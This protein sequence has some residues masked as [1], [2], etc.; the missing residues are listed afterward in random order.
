MTTEE[1]NTKDKEQEAICQKWIQEQLELAGRVHIPD[2]GDWTDGRV[3][4][5][6]DDFSL[7]SL[8]ESINDAFTTTSSSSS[9]P[10]YYGGVDVS[11]PKHETD[12]SVAVYVILDA[13]TLQVV[14]K[15]HKYFHLEI[16]YIPTFLAFR[17]IGPLERLIATQRRVRPSLTP[18]AIWVDGNGALHPRGAGIACFVGVRTNIPTIGIGKTLYCMG[19]LSHKLIDNG[20]N[21]A[22][23]RARNA[24][25]R[26]A[27]EIDNDIN[28][29]NNRV[30]FD[31]QVLKARE[32]KEDDEKADD[33]SIDTGA[34]VETMAPYC[35]GLAIPLGVSDANR[36]QIVL[37]IQRNDGQ[38][39]LAYALVGHGGHVQGTSASRQQRAGGTKNPIFVSVGHGLSLR[40]AVELTAAVSLARIPE[41][42]R[43]A[44]LRGRKL[45]RQVP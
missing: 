30:L 25:P 44:D 18:R 41:P 39:I 36:D 24:L 6:S 37:A 42:V 14:Y 22:L 31:Q 16:P 34:H 7:V 21:Q 10:I 26:L 3:V 4:A 15:D 45:M 20:V 40:M 9:V 5:A 28:N 11:F 19:G 38:P 33:Q 13:R 27:S 32:S 8:V 23:V 2:E 12:P 29:N 43:Q 17:E 35:R 1:D